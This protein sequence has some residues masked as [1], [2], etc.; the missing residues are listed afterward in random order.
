M[1]EIDTKDCEPRDDTQ[2]DD[3]TRQA[4]KALLTCIREAED[5]TDLCRRVEE[6]AQ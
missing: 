3:T 5:F 6:A 4:L 2:L 1:A